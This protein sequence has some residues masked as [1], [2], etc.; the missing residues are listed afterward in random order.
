MYRWYF[1]IE[2]VDAF[3]GLFDPFREPLQRSPSFV[4][5]KIALLLRNEN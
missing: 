5:Q 2:V 3:I 4:P 1:E